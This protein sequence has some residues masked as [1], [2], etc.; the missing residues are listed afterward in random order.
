MPSAKERAKALAKEMMQ[1]LKESKAAEARAKQL[2]KEVEQALAEV[3]AETESSL[4]ITEYPSGR[5]ECQSCGHSTLFT[6]P[7]QNLPAC[8]NCGHR[9]YVGAEPKIIKKKPPPP[10]K[11]PAGMY[12]CANCRAR[13]AVVE[14][15]DSLSPC[16]LCGHKKL[17][18]L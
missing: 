4:I 11:F 12:E 8:D 6:E 2:S 18:P 10:K 15:S 5:Y 13:V 17:R 9:K 14:G 16:D 1:A 3:K 7:T